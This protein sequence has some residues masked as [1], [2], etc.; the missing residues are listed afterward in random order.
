[1]FQIAEIGDEEALNEEIGF[2]SQD[3]LEVGL[4]VIDSA[5]RE[6]SSAPPDT[7][8]KQY[9]VVIRTRAVLVLKKVN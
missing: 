8:T 7:R 3:L 5:S 9:W 1:M 4:K 2:L 6:I